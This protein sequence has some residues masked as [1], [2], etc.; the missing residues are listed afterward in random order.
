MK[1]GLILPNVSACQPYQFRL[2]EYDWG[3]TLS[4]QQVSTAVPR[5]DC[6]DNRILDISENVE[7]NHAGVPK[8]MLH[9][10]RDRAI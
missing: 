3:A 1:Y 7:Q 5:Q 4:A 6:T 8:I 2:T 9:L 10:D